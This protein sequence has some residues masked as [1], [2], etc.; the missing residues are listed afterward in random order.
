MNTPAI[1][2]KTFEAMKHDPEHFGIYLETLRALELISSPIERARLIHQLV[3]HFNQEVF[4][5]ELVKA[6]SPCEAGCSACCFTQVSVTADEAQL[7][8]EHLPE[9][10]PPRFEQ[11]S[12]C[13]NDFL[14]FSRLPY[15]SRQ[16]VF[17]DHESRC[18][19]YQDRPSVCRTN[20]VLGE[21][22]QCDTSTEFRPQRLVRTS[23]ADMVIYAAF[24]FSA[25]NGALASE[26]G[27]LLI[28]GKVG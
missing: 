2:K 4:N 8:L 3:D 9:T 13:G 7:L 12:Q 19:V 24:E 1:A 27:K 15:S 18:S 17:L 22:S 23:K 16:C 14:A 11:Q 21:A 5:H 6:L 26:L 28:E 20:A 10:P 25:K